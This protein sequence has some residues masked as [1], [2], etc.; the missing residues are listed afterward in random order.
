MKGNY[1]ETKKIT[2]FPGSFGRSCLCLSIYKLSIAGSL[3]DLTVKFTLKF[4]LTKISTTTCDD[5]NV[6]ALSLLIS[7]EH[8]DEL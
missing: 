1:V 6:I 7:R 5:Q 8:V 2:V 4:T 3:Q